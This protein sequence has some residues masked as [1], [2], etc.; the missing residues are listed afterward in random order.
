MVDQLDDDKI[1]NVYYVELVVLVESM[2]DKVLVVVMVDD[3]DY[4]VD[5]LELDDNTM[6][7]VPHV[8]VVNNVHIHGH[9]V[10]VNYI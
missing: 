3:D 4:N 2:D 6:V 5:V 7:E 10:Y 8:L 1:V 9:D